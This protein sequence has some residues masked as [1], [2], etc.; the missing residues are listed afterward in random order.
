MLITLAVTFT[1]M[2]LGHPANRTDYKPIHPHNCSIYHGN[3]TYNYSISGN[4]STQGNRP[5]LGF[6]GQDNNFTIPYVIPTSVPA[7]IPDDKDSP[8]D[9]NEGNLIQKSEVTAHSITSMDV[10]LA[11]LFAVALVAAFL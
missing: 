3:S 9:D 1:A 2:V 4:Y 5:P 10:S 7:D 6:V 8:D 11:L